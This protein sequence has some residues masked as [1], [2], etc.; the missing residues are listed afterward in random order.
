MVAIVAALA[1]LLALLVGLLAVPVVFVIDAERGET[2]SAQWQVSWLFGLV[3]VR[4]PNRR[5]ASSTPA[6]DTRPAH[7]STNGRKGAPR[8]GSAVLRTRG[9]V[10]RVVQL[11]I[12]LSRK[13]E[14]ERFHVD[15]AFGFENPADT[16]FVY[17]C[18]APLLVLAA[19]RGLDIQC[20]PM[21]FESGVRGLLGA[22]IRAR[23]L[24][25]LGTIV[26]FLVSP[27]VVR[28]VNAAWR[29]KR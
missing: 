13:V 4:S 5:A 11:V 15:A 3:N 7:V 9:L 1:G 23:P 18:L 19:A 29:A 21:F 22:T 6:S 10:R 17:G 28:A 8:S 16:G 26:G 20:M 24:I 25:V 12:A 2:V 14:L 27:P